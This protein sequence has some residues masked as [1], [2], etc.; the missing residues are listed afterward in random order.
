LSLFIADRDL[1][2]FETRSIF[3]DIFIYVPPCEFLLKLSHWV[4]QTFSA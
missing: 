4:M 3:G 1:T 2:K